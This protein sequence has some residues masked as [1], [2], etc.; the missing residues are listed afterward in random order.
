MERYD[1]YFGVKN[2]IR[3]YITHHYTAAELAELMQDRDE[4]AERLN[5]DLLI[6]DSVTGNAS[7]SYTCNAW[8]AE[9]YIA[10][11]FD[12]LAEALREFGCD[13]VDVLEKGAEWCDV[14]I[15][16][17][18]LSGCICEALEEIES[19]MEEANA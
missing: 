6:C 18:V 13:G 3:T 9:E 1:Y 19:E 14:T 2:D 12:L 15:R 11:N 10:H 4:F 8:K 7:G 5:D 17:Y 16:C